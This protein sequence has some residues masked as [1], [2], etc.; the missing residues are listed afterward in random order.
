MSGRARDETRTNLRQMEQV[1]RGS[2]TIELA[3]VLRF[4]DIAVDALAEAREE[5]DALNVYPVPD[6]DTGTNMY[7]TVAAARDAL[8][9]ADPAD[10]ARPPDRPGRPAQ[11]RAPGRARQQRSDP[12]PDARRA[13]HHDRERRP[14]SATPASWPGLCGRRP[15]ARTPPSGRPSRAPSSRVVR[16]AAEAAEARA[17]EPGARA[18]DVFTA[19]AAAAREALAQHPGAA[20]RAAR[21]RRRRR[22]RPRPQ[23]HPR[24]RRDG[25][26]R[27][28]ADRRSP[29]RSAR[30]ASRSRRRRASTRP[31]ARRAGVRGDVPARRRRR[32]AC[33]PSRTSLAGL[34]DSLVVVGGDGLWNVHVHV[35]D[36]GAAVEAGIAAGRPHRIRV[37]HFA[38]QVGRRPARRASTTRT[39]RQVVAV[40]AGPGLEKLFEEAGA[41]VVVG[42]PGQPPVDRHDPRGHP[43]LR[44]RRR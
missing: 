41:T 35:D 44:R 27:P 16:A 37:T 38:E 11:R 18:R 26:H 15:T 6:G 5:I 10:D 12:Q 19:A 24:R 36:V 39:G 14:R 9:E 34:G 43:R 17:A 31:D 2:G 23:R 28:A 29:R 20:R 32:P 42:G 3:V 22:G 13:G 30:T 25:A 33:P 40:A 1:P 21:R 8:R 4:V 7:L